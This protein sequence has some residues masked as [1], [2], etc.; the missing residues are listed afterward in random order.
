[1]PTAVAVLVLGGSLAGLDASAP[2]GG[3]SADADPIRGRWKVVEAWHDG[4]P[5]SA[6]AGEILEFRGGTFRHDDGRGTYALNP[7][8]DPKEIDLTGVLDLPVRGD[9]V[10][11]GVY[12]LRGRLLRICL[13]SPSLLPDGDGTLKVVQPSIRPR[14]FDSK[15][16][17]TLLVLRRLPE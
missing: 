5:D 4:N 16:W 1:M 10:Q 7:R 13:G 14:G 17:K 6:F 12:D 8:T 3:K 15:G 2:A 11:R 9:N